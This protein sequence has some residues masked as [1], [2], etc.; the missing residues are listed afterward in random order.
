MSGLIVPFKGLIP[1]VAP[2]AFVAPN[3]TLIGAVEVAANGR[4]W[5][6]SSCAATG[7]ESALAKIPTCRM[8]WWYRS[9]R[10][11]F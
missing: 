2:S 11:G 9:P 3:A 10:A 6:A 1:K 7:R 4:I 8:A 5:L